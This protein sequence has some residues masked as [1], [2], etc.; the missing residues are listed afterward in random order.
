MLMRG[1]VSQMQILIISYVFPPCT[2]GAATV[3]YNLC[4]YLPKNCFNVITTKKEFCIRRGIHDKDYELNC[5]TIRLPARTS[6]SIDMVVF[7]VLTIFK[8]LSLNKK[9]KITCILTVHPYFYDLLGAYIL[10]KLTRKPYV[11]YMH[12]LFSELK[13]NALLYRIWLSLEKRVFSNA[14]KILVMN[15]E[16]RKHYYERGIR[17]VSIFPPSIDYDHYDGK[18]LIIAKPEASPTELRIAYTGSVY[19][20]QETA[21][22]TF[23]KAAKKVSDV[24]AMFATPSQKGYLK[25]SLKES[26]KDVNV[27]FLPKKECIKL[28][29][30]A[31]VLFLPLSSDFTH[32]D[33]VQCAFPC[34]LLDYLVAGK[35][36]LAVVPKG[37]FVESFV[38]KHEVGL[39]VNELS[40]EKIAAAIQELK[41]LNKREA[42]SQNALKTARLFD[43]KIWTG[44]LCSVLKDVTHT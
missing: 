6:T 24:H 5:N 34:K 23:L 28:Q 11:V 27:G 16:Y 36:I 14:A 13:R 12:D 33:E 39:V 1:Y 40:E 9:G 4:K 31:D 10:Q 7:L 29:K 25:S 18:D 38:R 22:L 21:V 26:L 2:T 20:A 32:P 42:F 41:D 30:E 43:A 17:K 19:G 15:E 44:R 8:G 3:M 37:S 35:P